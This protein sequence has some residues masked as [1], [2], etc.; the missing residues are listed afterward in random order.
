M[1]NPT[2]Q[3]GSTDK[4]ISKYVFPELSALTVVYSKQ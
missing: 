3:R 4:G 1:T 2:L